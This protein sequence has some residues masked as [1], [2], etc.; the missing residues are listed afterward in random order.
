MKTFT[1]CLLLLAGMIFGCKNDDDAMEPS[2]SATN[3]NTTTNGG[4]FDPTTS[5]YSYVYYYYSGVV[6]DITNGTNL[7]GY[8]IRQE[9]ACCT[10]SQVLD[11]TGAYVLGACT[12]TQAQYVCDL[13][14]PDVFLYDP[15]DSLVASWN[16]SKSLLIQGDTI[17]YNFVY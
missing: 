1:L 15:N 10:P 13:H 9:N 8:T 11:S 5:S 16:F 17:T 2:S 6:T 7:D 12:W 14:D 3:T 4:T